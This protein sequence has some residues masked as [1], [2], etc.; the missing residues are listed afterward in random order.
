M[1][2]YLNLG[3]MQS[4]ESAKD[5]ETCLSRIER[6]VENLMAGMNPPELV[7]GVELAIGCHWAADENVTGGDPIPGKVIDRLSAIA[8]QH[9]IYLIPG[10]MV[11][12][13]RKDGEEV[14]YNSIPIFSP[15]GALIDVYRKICPYYPVESAITP[16]DRYVTFTIKEKNIKVGVLNCHDWC[17]PEISRNLALMGAEILIKPSID[18][19]GLYDVCRSIAPTRAFENQAYFISVNHAG[20]RGGSYAYGHSMVAEPDGRILYE[21]GHTPVSLTLTLNLDKVSDTRRYG[22]NYTE[23]LLRQLKLF[24]P[25]M[26]YADHFEKAPVYQNLPEPD[27]SVS[28]RISTLQKEGLLFRK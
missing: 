10:S 13:A 26:P 23:Q 11:E 17:F 21:A 25:P 28:S 15:D 6:D 2:R 8:K 20:E 7:V 19:E 22:T 24:H 3:I 5:F 12:A 16:G 9:R 1:S 27:L 14:R 4:G 18:P